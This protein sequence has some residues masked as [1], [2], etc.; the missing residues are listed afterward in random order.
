MSAEPIRQMNLSVF[1]LLS[2]LS[3]VVFTFIFFNPNS[4]LAFAGVP[5]NNHYPYFFQS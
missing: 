1:Y 3:F 5:S 2:V 4:L